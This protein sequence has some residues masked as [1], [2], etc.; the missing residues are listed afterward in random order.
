M[1]VS[2]TAGLQLQPAGPHSGA[3]AGVATSREQLI[4]TA[5]AE[6]AALGRAAV[7]IGGDWNTPPGESM[8][9]LGALGGGGW[10]DAG[11]A[12][13]F[14]DVQTYRSPRGSS[15]LDY[16]V[17]NT[18]AMQLVCGYEVNTA[19]ANPAH[20]PVTVILGGRSYS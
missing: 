18:A 10:H 9:L 5:L 12:C 16:W 4:A 17:A 3:A 19:A 11:R 20:C 8:C 2:G 13:G 7:L 1:Q 14:G 6:G 15:R